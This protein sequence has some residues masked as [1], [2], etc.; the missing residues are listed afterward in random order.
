MS[1][2]IYIPPKWYTRAVLRK[3]ALCA[4]SHITL[5][6]SL[7][8]QACFGRM[9]CVTSGF[10]WFHQQLFNSPA[11]KIKIFSG[12]TI[13]LAA[14]TATQSR[15]PKLESTLMKCTR[16]GIPPS[17]VLTHSFSHVLVHSPHPF[18]SKQSSP[19]S[20]KRILVTYLQSPHIPSHPY[21]LTSSLPHPLTH[22]TPSLPLLLYTGAYQEV[23]M[24]LLSGHD[25]Y[26]VTSG[27]R[28]R[29]TIAPH[30]QGHVDLITL[31]LDAGT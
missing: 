26:H 27:W 9:V 16:R 25:A 11:L 8:T 29:S 13:F 10:V 30:M 17:N 12:L 5:L 19:G 6:F 1:L 14:I 21:P 15:N 2:S 28:S 7:V 31:L 23:L 22:F 20:H 24:L 4:G 3:S 18:K